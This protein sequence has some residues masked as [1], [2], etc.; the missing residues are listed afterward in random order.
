MN[1]MNKTTRDSVL[2]LAVA[3]AV[4]AAVLVVF[5]YREAHGLP[6]HRPIASSRPFLFA[7]S[8][9]TIF[10]FTVQQWRHSWGTTRFWVVLTS[11]FIAFVP[12]QWLVTSYTMQHL[13]LFI[14]IAML[15]VVALDFILQRLVTRE[16]GL[17]RKG[18]VPRQN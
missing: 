3:I 18:R 2:Y 5:W 17:R 13:I 9:L 12:L 8:A 10:G 1:D 4:V 15:E 6:T 11:L 14:M 16:S 7:A